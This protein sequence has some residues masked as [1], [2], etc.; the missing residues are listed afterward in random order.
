MIADTSGV[1]TNDLAREVEAGL[2][3]SPKTLPCRFFYDKDGSVLFEQICELPEY[4]VTRTEKEILDD[5]ADEIATLLPKATTLVELGSGSSTKTRVLIEAFLRRHGSLRYVPMDISRTMLEESSIALLE[6]YAGLQITAIAAEYKAGLQRLEKV[7]PPAKLVLWL[8]S[9]IGNFDR[10]EAARF[11]RSVSHTMRPQDRLLAGIDLRKDR[12]TLVR[13]YD[14]GAG[15]TAQFNRNI[16]HRINRELDAEIDT[17]AFEHEA[18]YDENLGRV[19]MHLVSNREQNVRIGALEL[20]VSFDKGETIHTE[21]SYKYSIEEI[22]ELA[23]RS[24]L[25]VVERWFDDA[26]RFSLNLFR[27]KT[28]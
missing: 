1:H 25:C 26:R 12:S 19:E 10:G 11:L 7:Q 28:D 23:A 9:T 8:G 24:D 16:L 3:S 14:D 13:A 2:S 17:S 20:E 5:R 18:R 22:E 15:V 6:D 21:C 4:Y 27:G